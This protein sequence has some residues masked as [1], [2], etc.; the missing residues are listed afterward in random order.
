[1]LRLHGA[2]LETSRPKI[3]SEPF[4]LPHLR[5]EPPDGQ[6]G[7]HPLTT[8]SF[9]E[10]LHLLVQNPSCLLWSPPPILHWAHPGMCPS[11]GSKLSPFSLS[12]V[13]MPAESWF[14]QVLPWLWDLFVECGLSQVSSPLEPQFPLLWK[15]QI[16]L[17][18]KMS[19]S[20]MI[21]LCVNSARIHSL[22]QGQVFTD[23]GVIY[24]F[25]WYEGTVAI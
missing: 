18:N 25:S 1:M 11:S 24:L 23:R 22:N 16:V 13:S 19:P 17:S 7:L 21:L 8:L 20:R 5:H 14:I 12:S 10:V 4:P 9:A 3:W 2:C 6:A 15:E